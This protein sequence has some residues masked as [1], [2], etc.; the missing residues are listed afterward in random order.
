M[1]DLWAGYHSTNENTVREFIDY[2][3]SLQIA[4]YKV[5]KANLSQFGTNAPTATEFENTLGTAT[6]I[7]DG[8]GSYNLVITGAFPDDD[9]VWVPM[10]LCKNQGM[11]IP[12]I[13]D[14]NTLNLEAISAANG[15][16]DKTSIEIYVYP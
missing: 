16:L 9:K 12:T 2:L 1:I 6:W 15:D 7:Y 3:F 10:V 11:L 5:Y 8:V 13:I 4:D 14:N